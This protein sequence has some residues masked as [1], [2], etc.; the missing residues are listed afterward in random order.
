M[1]Y[2]VFNLGTLCVVKAVNSTY[3]VAC[4]SADSFKRNRIVIVFNIN[5]VAVNCEFNILDIFIRI[6]LSK[7]CCVCLNFLFAELST[8]TED[9]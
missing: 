4:D 2:S 3:K 5:I 6:S 8:P 7:L 9:F 1:L